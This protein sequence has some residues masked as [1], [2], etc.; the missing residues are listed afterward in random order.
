MRKMAY[1]LA[2]VI[3]LSLGL[4]PALANP[5]PVGEQRLEELR[6]NWENARSEY[7]AA[8]ISEMNAEDAEIKQK[9]NGL[10]LEKD[11]SQREKLIREAK[12][13]REKRER[14]N[15]KVRAVNVS[16]V[17][18]YSNRRNKFFALFTHTK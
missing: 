10:A 1:I 8:L 6:K 14:L 12:D 16:D 18:K 15:E 2:A 9:E 11:K 13:L 5:E 7:R 3:F 4:S 17:V